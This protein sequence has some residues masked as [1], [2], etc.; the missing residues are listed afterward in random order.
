MISRLT[1]TAQTFAVVLLAYFAYAMIAAP[2]IEPNIEVVQAEW[3]PNTNRN[4]TQVDQTLFPVGAWELGQPKVLETNQGTLLFDDYKQLEN[5]DLRLPRC[6]LISYID[7]PKDDDASQSSSPVAEAVPNRSSPESTSKASRRPVV[8][9]AS[10]GAVLS[11]DPPPDFMLGKFGQLVGGKLQGDVTIYS[12][13]TNAA[14]DDGLRVTTK[15]IQIDRKRIW[16]PSEVDFR[17]GQNRAQGRDLSIHL[18]QPQTIAGRKKAAM[19]RIRSL[20]L[21]HVDEVNLQIEG[22]MFAMMKGPEQ[23]RSAPHQPAASLPI[24]RSAT[25]VEI[26]CQ[27]PFRFDFDALIASLEERVDVI[28]HNLDGPSDQLNCELL[29]IHFAPKG[30]EA[31]DPGVSIPEVSPEPSS[32]SRSSRP[33]PMEPRK[34]IAVGFPVMI[35]APSMRAG[36]RAKRIEYDF[37]TRRVELSGSENATLFSEQF[38]VEAPRLEYELLEGGRLGRLQAAGPGLARGQMGKEK[39][40]FQANWAGTV[41]L[42]PQGKNKVLSLMGQANLSLTGIATLKANELHL[43]LLEVPRPGTDQVD[44]HA[45]RMLASGQIELDSKQLI[46]FLSEAQIWFRQPTLDEIAAATVEG[47]DAARSTDLFGRASGA[48]AKVPKKMQLTAGVLRGQVVM[49]ETPEL[50][51]LD[52][53]NDVHVIEYQPVAKSALDIAAQRVVLENGNNPNAELTLTGAPARFSAEG[54]TLDGSLVRVQLASNVAEVVGPGSM[55]MLPQQVALGTGASGQPKPLNVLWKQGMHFDGQTARFDGKVETHGG[56]L[57]KQQQNVQFVASGDSLEV[58]L[59]R[60]IKFTDPAPDGVDASRL[61]FLGLAHVESRTVESSGA[62]TALDSLSIHDLVIDRS[63]GQV[64]GNGPGYIIHRGPNPEKKQ[65]PATRSPMPDLIFL[66]VDFENQMVGNIDTREVQFLNGTRTI[67]GPIGTWE[68]TL[69]SQRPD[70]L[71]ANSV[72]LTSRRLAV[73]DMRTTS[74][75]ENAIEVEATGNAQI[76]GRQFAAAADRVFYVRAKDQLVLEGAGRPKATLKFQHQEGGPWQPLSARRI[77]FY[78]KTRQF[79]LD[80]FELELNVQGLMTR[81]PA[82]PR[83]NV[84]PSRIPPT[85]TQPPAG[86]PPEFAPPNDP[87]PGYAPPNDP[88]PGYAPPGYRPPNAGPPTNP[89]PA[90]GPLGTRSDPNALPSQAYRNQPTRSAASR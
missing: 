74:G 25:P 61:S 19:G 79:A 80:D 5:G 40:P 55:F 17:F 67:F 8:M 38:F 75:S 42:L 65:G 31:V 10:E 23:P 57:T 68:Q 87:P 76:Q 59:N 84:T 82:A 21:V 49:T 47:S 60:P 51:S 12:P 45:D 83:S 34:I 90:Y 69:D 62:L 63:N 37:L 52:L 7:P 24:V 11:F 35:R 77:L 58:V 48:D 28:R 50:E 29:E 33:G 85:G 18:E 54:M 2:L 26:K 30:N 86:T 20:E 89:S 39:R 71:A 72:I 70:L 1:R 15:N 64:E 44:I 14:S 88:P 41:S 66:R 46:A 13:A 43:Y 53:Q 81:T 73:A 4:L 78:P 32:T 3:E 36:A 6:T 27:G 22:D 56:H 9:R 16:A